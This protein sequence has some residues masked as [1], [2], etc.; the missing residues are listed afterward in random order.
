MGGVLAV[1][2]F[3]WVTGGAD[4]DPQVARPG[5]V[6]RLPNPRSTWPWRKQGAETDRDTRGWIKAKARL[7]VLALG[8]IERP[9]WWLSFFLSFCF[10]AWAC[11]LSCPALPC[12]FFCRPA[13][14]SCTPTP[15]THI[16]SPLLPSHPLRFPFPGP[17]G[18]GCGMGRFP[19]TPTCVFVSSHFTYARQEFVLPEFRSTNKNGRPWPGRRYAYSL[20]EAARHNDPRT[21]LPVSTTKACPVLACASPKAF[22]PSPGSRWEGKN[23][24]PQLRH[25]PKR[26]RGGGGGT[27]GTKH[28]A[29]AHTRHDTGR[30]DDF[31]RTRHLP[32]RL[33]L[34][35]LLQALLLLLLARAKAGGGGD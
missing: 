22:Q 1:R 32:A 5:C 25:W 16:P 6:S 19:P 15:K 24:G 30:K 33:H 2:T 10:A 21:S 4:P 11:F 27:Q 34:L 28:S 29:T 26:E 14:P 20:L 7:R 12:S 18:G 8:Y 9:T 17:G 13:A 23:N 35:D 3:E 31:L